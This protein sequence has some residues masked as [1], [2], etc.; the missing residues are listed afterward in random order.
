MERIHI[1]HT[2]DVHS[3]F[4]HWPRIQKLLLDRK[5]LH[6]EAGEECYIFDIG[7]HMDRYH[8]Y[9]DATR[10]K[11]NT[12]IL[13]ESG[14][15]AV[16]IGNNEGITLPYEDLDHMYGHA[17][18]DVIIANLFNNEGNI[19]D[20]ATPYRVYVTNNDC[21]IAVIGLTAFF[22]HFYS[23]LGWNLSEPFSELKRLL[24]T[25][26]NRCDAIVL[27]SHLGIHDDE[28]LAEEFP[29]IDVILGAHTH[30]ILHT[31]K[32]V[33]HTLLAAAG[34]YGMF[35]GHVTLTIDDKRIVSKE[36]ILYDT[37]DLPP[38]DNETKMIDF[39]YAEGKEQLSQ[40]FLNIPPIKG[41]KS[42]LSLI[43]CQALKDWC[44]ADC[45]F[46]NEGM[47]LQDMKSGAV[48]DFDLLTI[49]PHPINPCVV[50]LTGNEL[51]E[52]LIQSQ[53]EGWPDLKIKGF[54]FRGTFMGEMVYEGIEIE[55]LKSGFNFRI[56][57]SEL[58]GDRRYRVAIP[59]MYTFGMFF[60]EIKRAKNKTF[61]FPE[62]LRDILKW[63]LISTFQG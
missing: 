41:T 34:K 27:L 36:A 42:N 21:R 33:N 52:V 56:Q 4:E 15:T 3:H 51:K 8:P 55:K 16:T 26:K 45:A 11:G 60:P 39:W 12:D 48:S 49:C 10:G 61:F 50:N 38:V 14:Y 28:R 7:D 57:S 20:W 2:N 53:D 9:S 13:N 25:L 46:I 44:K 6:K 18:F 23:L 35:V 32:L 22:S 63:K 30:H 47:I 17:Q 5:E 24:D 59:D 54:G 40:V 19:P 37:N 1:Y 58:E 31:G 62:F 43:L 29:E